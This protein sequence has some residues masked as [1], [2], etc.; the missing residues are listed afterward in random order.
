MRRVVWSPARR[1]E[2]GTSWAAI[3][4]AAL[5]AFVLVAIVGARA[6]LAAPVPTFTPTGDGWTL[7]PKWHVTIMGDAQPEA[8]LVKVEDGTLRITAGGSDIWTDNDNGV[9]LW[10]PA[11]GD[12]EAI[13]EI[14]SITKISDSLNSNKVG[15]M[16]RPNLDNHSAHIYAIAMPKGT[17]LQARTDVGEQA[18]P[19]SGDAGRLPW[20][21]GSGN[22]PTMWMRLVRLGNKFTASRS[23]DAGKTWERIHDDAH[24]D[25]DTIE[26][27]MPD[28]VLLGISVGAIHG[29][30]DTT[31]VDAVVGP[32]Q[33]KQLDT[34]PTVN[35]L[36]AATATDAS[37]EP[38]AGSS[39]IVKKGT[40]IVA[41]TLTT[42]GPSNTGSFFLEPGLYTIETADTDKNA[43]STPTPFEVKTGE[44]AEIKVAV[45]TAK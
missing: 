39:L 20:G 1:G 4:Q 42:V 30:S 37:G 33:Y 19:S 43:A 14:R 16:V 3:C 25:T 22:G 9:F 32:F 27:E 12:F 38:V 18:G 6:A 34:R 11:N 23:F 44:A 29:T 8:N 41:T 15:I 31:L 40:D 35:G 10:Q 26:L 36:L 45:G 13:L 24:P 2:A 17:H 5:F 7:D 28:D 21:D